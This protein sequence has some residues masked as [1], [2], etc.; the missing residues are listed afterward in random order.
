MI[1]LFQK[2]DT[3]APY[4][5]KVLRCLP[6]SQ[7]AGKHKPEKGQSNNFFFENVAWFLD[8]KMRID[9]RQTQVYLAQNV[10]KTSC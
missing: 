7:W 8:H 1:Y 5:L 2:K 6:K 4:L 9:L 3:I 10:C